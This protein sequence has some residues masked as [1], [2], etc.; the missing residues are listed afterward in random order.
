ML[1]LRRKI[2]KFYSTTKYINKICKYL[3]PGVVEYNVPP[4]VEE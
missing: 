4:G 1:Y 3:P 2:K